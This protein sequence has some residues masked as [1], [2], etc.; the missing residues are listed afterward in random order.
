MRD[1]RRG[2]EGC[3]KENPHSALEDEIGY[4]QKKLASLLAK[5][6]SSEQ[7][8]IYTIINI[9]HLLLKKI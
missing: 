2:L 4:L 8:T 7:G 3:P 1:L 6:S 9:G 5:G